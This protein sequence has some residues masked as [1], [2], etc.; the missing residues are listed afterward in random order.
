[1]PMFILISDHARTLKPHA[2]TISL[3]ERQV[4]VRTL[5]PHAGA[6]SLTERIP[7]PA[8]FHNT[9]VYPHSRPCTHPKTSRGYDVPGRAQGPGTHPKTSRGCDVPGR[10]YPLAQRHVIMRCLFLI[11]T[12]C[13]HPKASRGCDFPGRTQGVHARTLNLHQ[14]RYPWAS[15]FMAQC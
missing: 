14:V 10:A 4:H 11:S 9:Y 1:M 5:K 2:A 6:I 15:V 3:G 12:A 13:P 7:G 8:F